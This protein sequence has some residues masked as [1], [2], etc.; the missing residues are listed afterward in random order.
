MYIARSYTNKRK[1]WGHFIKI[2]FLYS[3]DGCL[4]NLVGDLICY[5]AK[6]KQG[7]SPQGEPWLCIWI[8]TWRTSRGKWGAFQFDHMPKTGSL[9]KMATPAWRT[10]KHK[11]FHNAESESNKTLAEKYSVVHERWATL[12][13]HCPVVS[14]SLPL[15]QA[16]QAEIAFIELC[17]G[18]MLKNII[19]KYFF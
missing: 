14:R 13:I 11:V 19:E 2:F 3:W 9:T 10:V 7:F 1:L 6:S 5:C 4:M 15:Y 8:L 18:V 16:R 12:H 17:F